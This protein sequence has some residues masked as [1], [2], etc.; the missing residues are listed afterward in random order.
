MK[1]YSNKSDNLSTKVIFLTK[2]LVLVHCFTIC[3]DLP[4]FSQ[5]A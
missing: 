4:Q 3:N 5:I 2:H 1:F